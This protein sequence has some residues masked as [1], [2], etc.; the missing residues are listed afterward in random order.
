MVA[1]NGEGQKKVRQAGSYELVQMNL[2]IFWLNRND[3]W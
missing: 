2:L 3:L 1:A